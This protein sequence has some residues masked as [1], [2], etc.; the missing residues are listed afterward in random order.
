MLPTV[1]VVVG[2]ACE[3]VNS[4]FR[5]T[6]IR[7]ILRTHFSTI[8]APLSFTLVD[9]EW[10]WYWVEWHCFLYCY[11]MY[12]PRQMEW[13]WYWVEWHWYWVE[14]H[15]YWVEWHCF[16]DCYHMYPPRQMEW[17]WYSVSFHPMSLSF[18][19]SRGYPD[20]PACWCSGPQ[21]R[22]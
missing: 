15:W 14:W 22:F 11:H 17:H 4:G 19:L 16:L 1:P 7:M 8:T 6:L 5:E 21:E 12:P 20:Q 3:S 13:Q 10:H 9:L 2:W 18:H